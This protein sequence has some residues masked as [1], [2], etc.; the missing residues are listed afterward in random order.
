MHFKDMASCGIAVWDRCNLCPA[1]KP[2]SQ[3]GK[4]GDTKKMFCI[5]RSIFELLVTIVTAPQCYT[6][7]V[8]PDGPQAY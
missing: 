8:V 6:P 7:V 4:S 1:R 3:R 5:T 2:G